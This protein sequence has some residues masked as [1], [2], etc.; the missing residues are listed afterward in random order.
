MQS[1]WSTERRRPGVM[2]KDEVTAW[3]PLSFHDLKTIINCDEK[4]LD[5]IL[6]SNIDREDRPFQQLR[7]VGDWGERF[8]PVNGCHGASTNNSIYGGKSIIHRGSAA[9]IYTALPSLL[10]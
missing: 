10:F 2:P 9:A 4:A 6:Q 7:M 3:Y 5:S 1:H 8:V